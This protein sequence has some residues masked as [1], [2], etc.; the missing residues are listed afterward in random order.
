M[1]PDHIIFCL[2]QPSL[3]SKGAQDMLSA[4][5]QATKG[6]DCPVQAIRLEGEGAGLADALRTAQT[7]GAKSVRVQPIGFPMAA[8]L[9]VWLPGAVAHWQASQGAGTHVWLA[10]PPAPDAILPAM[11]AA[12]LAGPAPRP[13]RD[14]KPSLGKPGWQYV[15]DHDTHI[16]ICTGPRCAFRGAGTLLSHLKEML[17][18]AGLSDR[19]L[20]TATGCLFPCN[21]GPL[22]ALYPRNDWYLIPDEDALRGLVCDV[23]GKGGDL[24]HLRLAQRPA[25]RVAS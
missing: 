20:T 22:V 18:G 25:R 1:I 11:I 21:Q 15:P 10:A 4:L 5:L 2:S 6:M 7:A 9:M 19:C 24:P 23:I 13:A 3:S 12:A 16:L 8:N 14:A 17:A